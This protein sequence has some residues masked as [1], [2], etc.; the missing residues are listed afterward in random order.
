MAE[1]G[2]RRPESVLVL[3]YT[4][5][6]EVLL[7]QRRTPADYWQSVTGSLE[8]GESPSAAA[9]RELREETGLDAPVIDCHRTYTFPIHPAWRARYAPGTATNR[10]H[11]FRIACT[12]R[13]PVRLNPQE[14]RAL[15]WLPRAAAAALASSWSN[16][17]AILE[18]VVDDRAPG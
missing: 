14:H 10:E 4:R 8:W 13:P 15:R 5:A 9:R 3:I 17:A 7:L 2:Y 1:P 16:R 18:F 12:G 11:V 6:G